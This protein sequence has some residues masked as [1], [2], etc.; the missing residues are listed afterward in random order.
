MAD[1]W[2]SW[3][4]S[5]KQKAREKEYNHAYYLRNKDKWKTKYTDDTWT[6]S[7][8]KHEHGF[9]WR[10]KPTHGDMR[11]YMRYSNFRYGE[12]KNLGNNERWGVSGSG[13]SGYNEQYGMDAYLRKHGLYDDAPKYQGTSKM[14]EHTIS[15]STAVVP[16]NTLL[17][18][19]QKSIISL[20]KRMID[21]LLDIFR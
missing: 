12:G 9:D 1:L 5:P 16:P 13:I 15:K 4:N 8:G 14:S 17:S 6:T 20:G 7:D 11:E 18:R 21:S 2:H 3:G 19:V 10:P